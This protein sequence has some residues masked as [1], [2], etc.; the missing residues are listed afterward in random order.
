M[1]KVL[2]GKTM[3]GQILYDLAFTNLSAKYLARKHP[4]P[5]ARIRKMRDSREIKKL[6]RQNRLRAIVD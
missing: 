1:V 6:R 2:Y 5:I 3:L 4:M